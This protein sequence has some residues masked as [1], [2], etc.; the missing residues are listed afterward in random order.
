MAVVFSCSNMII[1]LRNHHSPSVKT[2][3]F[4]KGVFVNPINFKIASSF[5]RKSSPFAI[6]AY[7][8]E[9][10]QSQTEVQPK[11][12]TATPTNP[13][14]DNF[15]EPEEEPQP[16]S[17]KLA[18]AKAKAATALQ[19]SM[20]YQQV[21]KY[22][23]VTEAAIQSIIKENT[24]VF[25]VD[26]RANKKDIRNAFENMLKIKTKKI[27]TLINYDGTKKAYIQLPPENQAAT[28]AKRL[29]I[30]A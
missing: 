13:E 28:I 29:K 5:T 14:V 26:V 27:N 16:Q 30:L 1:Q 18:K 10:D 19:T 11:R 9:S 4:S 15:K 21:L 25:M 24:L 3:A 2:V 17:L 6:K 20:D 7:Q 12:S 8:N 23:L 22:P